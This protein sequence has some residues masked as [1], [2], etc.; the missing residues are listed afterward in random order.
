MRDSDVGRAMAQ[1]GRS[2]RWITLGLPLALI[3]AGCLGPVQVGPLQT[4]APSQTPQPTAV[5]ATATPTATPTTTATPTPLAVIEFAAIGDYGTV[6]TPAQAVSELVHSWTPDFVITLGDN[7]YG[8]DID[9][10]IGLYYHDFIFGYHGR[11]GTGAT[12]N[13]FWPSLGNHDW[14]GGLDRYLDFFT[15]PGNERY[16]D[17]EIGPVHLFALDADF[18]EPDGL[19]ADSR[20]AEWLRQALGESQSCWNVV[21]FHIPPYSS[22]TRHGSS[23]IMRWPF[24]AWGADVVMAGHEHHYERLLVDGIPYFVNGLGG[25]SIYP[26]GSPLPQSLARYNATFGA[27]HVTASL[28]TIQY[29]FVNIEGSVVDSYFHAG[30]CA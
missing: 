3:L 23:T 1:V 26:F 18:R 6:G 27:L 4:D 24:A 9:D 20:Q 29:R 22:G 14:D 8:A 5:P 10:D 13:R 21:Y 17:I 30:G 25:R 28:T 12:V 15:L 11:H 7:S 19:H 16:Y 2:S